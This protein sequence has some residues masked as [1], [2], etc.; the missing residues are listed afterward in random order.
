M[1]EFNVR[2]KL[3]NAEMKKGS[4]VAEALRDLA[5]WLES[6]PIEVRDSYA[7]RDIN[8]NTVGKAQVD[9]V[10]V[11]GK[12]HSPHFDEATTRV[13]GVEARQALI[14]VAVTLGAYT[15]WNGGD[16]CSDIAG[17]LNNL[18]DLPE[19]SDQS[20]DALDYWSDIAEEFG[21]EGDRPDRGDDGNPDGEMDA[22]EDGW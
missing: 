20:D 18:S 7:I 3:A 14:E 13:S 1:K 21:L 17:I 11:K 4:H 10:G 5:D 2:I 8:G 16:V 15:D 19:V 22:R 9:R 6:R 12:A